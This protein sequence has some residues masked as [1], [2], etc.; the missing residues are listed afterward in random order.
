[1]PNSLRNTYLKNGS[2]LLRSINFTGA[3][4]SIGTNTY[5]SVQYGAKMLQS[6]TCISKNACGITYSYSSQGLRNILSYGRIVT[7]ISKNACDIT[8]SYS[9]RGLRNILSY[10]GSVFMNNPLKIIQNITL[11]PIHVVVNMNIHMH[12]NDINDLKSREQQSLTN[13]VDEEQFTL[14]EQ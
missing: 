11:F 3:I 6:V 1:M 14:K 7:C 5:N 13:T 4:G 2:A 12:H 9:S 10:G 8:Y